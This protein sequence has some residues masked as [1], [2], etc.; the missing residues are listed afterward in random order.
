MA[1]GLAPRAGAAAGENQIGENRGQ[2]DR[3]LSAGLP[4]A[5]HQ[6]EPQTPVPARPKPKQAPFYLY[7]S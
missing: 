1:V 7:K 5:A 4:A 6:S 3:R 2:G